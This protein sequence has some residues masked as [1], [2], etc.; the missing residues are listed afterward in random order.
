MASSKAWSAPGGNITGISALGAEMAGKRHAYPVS[1]DAGA[2]T[3][4]K[5]EP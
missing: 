4:A 3:A 1:S 2:K 5:S